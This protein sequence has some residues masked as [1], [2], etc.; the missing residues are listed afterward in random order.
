MFGVSDLYVVARLRALT[1]EIKI[2]P[3][4]ILD[5]RWVS[6][7]QFQAE[8]SHP[9]LKM[10]AKLAEESSGGKGCEGDI[11]ETEHPSILAGRPPYKLYH[12]PV[13]EKK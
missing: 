2:C 13:S 8:V 12:A 10:V 6:L 7:K 11:V 9:L 1:D 4:E 3:S 5:A